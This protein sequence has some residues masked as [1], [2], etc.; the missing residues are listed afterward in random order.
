MLRQ[1]AWALYDYPALQNENSKELKMLTRT[2]EDKE[3]T[4]WGDEDSSFH[5]P[6]FFTCEG[7]DVIQVIKDIA[8]DNE[9]LL[10]VMGMQGAGMLARLILGSNSIRMI[11]N[12]KHP[13]LLIPPKHKYTGLKK[14][15]FATDLQKTD[16]KIAQSLLK[17][18]GYFDAE[19]LITHV[20]QSNNDV[21]ED[22]EYEHK[23]QE[24]LKSLDGK[25]CYNCIYSE[26]ID[27]GLDILKNKDIDMLI[28]GH[29]FRGFFESMIEGGHALR[30]AGTLEIPLL[31]IPEGKNIYF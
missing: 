12:T 19:L 10:I 8:A 21:I 17:F 11:K 3:K 26:N 7:G 5:P 20:I 15:A 28:M 2:L 9:T 16:I 30:Q 31:I 13:L 24:F 14:I 23:K 18:A 4:L 27:Y 22:E 25:T 29:R 6:V 1:T